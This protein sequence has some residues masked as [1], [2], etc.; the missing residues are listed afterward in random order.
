MQFQHRFPYVNGLLLMSE[1]KLIIAFCQ[2]V[3][4]GNTAEFAIALGPSVS[5]VVNIQS[6]Q[7]NMHYNTPVW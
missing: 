2:F 4:G 5:Q 6:H 7:K 3:I 1:K